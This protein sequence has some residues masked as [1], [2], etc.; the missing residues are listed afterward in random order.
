M[1]YFNLPPIKLK[2][3]GKA[4]EESLLDWLPGFPLEAPVDGLSDGGLH[5]VHIAHHQGS[6]QV[7]QVLV[8]LPI[9]KV[10]CDS[11]NTNTHIHKENV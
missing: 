2:R 3:K 11:R 10:I 5:Q 9:A 6:I 1:L 8:E 4:E 7:L